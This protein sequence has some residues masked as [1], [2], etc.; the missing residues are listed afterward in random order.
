MNTPQLLGADLISPAVHPHIVH[1]QGLWENGIGIWRPNKI[2][3]HG[4]I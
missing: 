4:N 2:S 3:S 1:K